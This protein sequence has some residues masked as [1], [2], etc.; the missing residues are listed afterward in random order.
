MQHVLCRNVTGVECDK[1]NLCCNF[2]TRCFFDVSLVRICIFKKSF[3]RRATEGSQSML[4]VSVCTTELPQKDTR[5]GKL[6]PTFSQGLFRVFPQVLS[7]N[8]SY[9]CD[10]SV[11][12]GDDRFKVSVTSDTL[13]TLAI[14]LNLSSAELTLYI[15][16]QCQRVL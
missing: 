11:R 4:R 9:A 7:R 10:Q 12:D 15:S 8:G 6:F 14:S 16:G 2:C 13:H 5:C 1:W 3:E